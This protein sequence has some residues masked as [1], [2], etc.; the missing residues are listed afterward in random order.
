[1]DSVVLTCTI[2]GTHESQA[3]SV[4]GTYTANVRSLAFFTT[5]LTNSFV[6]ITN[7]TDPFTF[8]ILENIGAVDAYVFFGRLSV[9][10]PAGKAIVISG[11]TAEDNS[12]TKAYASAN[13]IQARARTA[14]G[15]RITALIGY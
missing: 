7:D 2:A 13:T 12:G 1:M 11:S 14:S 9:G 8:A 5:D 15:T 10:L 3:V 4:G 6:G